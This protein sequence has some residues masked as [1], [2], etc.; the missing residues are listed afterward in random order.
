MQRRWLALS[1]V[2]WTGVAAASAP[3]LLAEPL[4][5]IPTPEEGAR[6]D[7]LAFAETF[8]NQVVRDQGY[9]A[10]A[11]ALG[12]EGTVRV[13]VVIGPDGRVKS[14][15]V[16]GVQR[17]SAARCRSRPEGARCG[18]SPGAARAAPRTGV[19]SRAADLVPARGVIG[20]RRIRGVD[21]R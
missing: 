13:T 11:L 3:G 1:F 8:V 15:S 6:L 10:E 12:L 17:A 4:P 19:Q 14:A 9:P 21:G 16:A 18:E 20:D 5:R 7:A 2:A